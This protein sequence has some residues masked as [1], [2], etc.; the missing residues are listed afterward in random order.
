M[1]R[2]WELGTHDKVLNFEYAMM[3]T[4][5]VI[6]MKL[7]INYGRHGCDF[8]HTQTFSINLLPPQ[9]LP[10]FLYSDDVRIVVLS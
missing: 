1:R 2:G 8:V 4:N 10:L 7:C 5:N 9:L 3:C 6:V